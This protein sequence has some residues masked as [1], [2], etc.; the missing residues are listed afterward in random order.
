MHADC[1]NRG[2]LS[3]Y[4]LHHR[5][6]FADMHNL[7]FNRPSAQRRTKLP[8]WPKQLETILQQSKLC[9][10]LDH[11]RWQ[12]RGAHVNSNKSQPFPTPM[13]NTQNETKPGIHADRQIVFNAGLSKSHRRSGGTSAAGDKCLRKRVATQASC[14]A[15]EMQVLQATT[16][17]TFNPIK[18]Y[19]A[20]QRHLAM[21]CQYSRHQKGRALR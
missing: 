10:S 11:S 9:T 4:I 3:C 6:G 13:L 15:N 7:F 1:C 14:L 19:H 2:I 5:F 17:G 18:Y 16:T 12:P 8:N 21:H 20:W